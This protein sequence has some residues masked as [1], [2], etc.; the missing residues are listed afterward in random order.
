VGID[1][2]AIGNEPRL[3]LF[4]FIAKDHDFSRFASC[5]RP[6][7]Q[8]SE[9]AGFKTLDD[10]HID[11]WPTLHRLDPTLLDFDYDHFPRGRVNWRKEDDRWLLVLDP[12]L[13]RAPFIT[14][15]VTLWN[16]PRH[17]L[18]VLTDDHYRSVASVGPPQ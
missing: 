3:G 18:L 14:L 17:R 12:K 13:S 15:I 11:I 9:V 2:V 5:S 7:S 1:T 16:I 10:G 6:F 4:W 8:V